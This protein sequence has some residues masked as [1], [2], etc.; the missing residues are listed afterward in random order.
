MLDLTALLTK[1]RIEPFGLP[2]MWTLAPEAPFVRF[3]H[4]PFPAGLFID[5]NDTFLI[6]AQRRPGH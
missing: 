5:G 1:D 4:R 2:G 3:A 6:D